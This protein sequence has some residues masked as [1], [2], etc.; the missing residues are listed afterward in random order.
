MADVQS[1]LRTLETATTVSTSSQFSAGQ[2]LA[3]CAQSLDMQRAGFPQMKPTLVRKTVGLIAR[4]VFLRKGTMSHSTDAV[5]PGAPEL[6]E[7]ELAESVSALRR[8]I[9]DF[10]SHEGSLSE[11][12]MFGAV[13]MQTAERLQAMHIANHADT[14][15]VT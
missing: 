10:L 13:D 9:T 4:S 2:T 8:A 14:F 3:H 1:W 15:T 6:P 12:F 5:I 7:V 11:H